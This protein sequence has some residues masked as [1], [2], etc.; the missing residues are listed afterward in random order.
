MLPSLSLS[1]MALIYLGQL[2]YAQD[3]KEMLD[4]MLASGKRCSVVSAKINSSPH[5][6][7]VSGFLGCLVFLSLLLSAEG[8]RGGV[9]L[10]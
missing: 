5:S 10:A 6:L 7:S 1:S 8:Y 3:L 9:L 4:V 2:I